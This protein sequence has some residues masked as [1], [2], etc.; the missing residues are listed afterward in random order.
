MINVYER[1]DIPE[2][3]LPQDPETMRDTRFWDKHLTEKEE[4]WG[5]L[6]V[7]IRRS[8]TAYDLRISNELQIDW[9]N[10][11]HLYEYKSKK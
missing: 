6:S 2:R 10:V 3:L 9:D 11:K 5:M 1:Y 8:E 4:Y 7:Q